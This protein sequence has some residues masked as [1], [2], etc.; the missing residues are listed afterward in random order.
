MDALYKD[1]H[2]IKKKLRELSRKVDDHLSD[3]SAH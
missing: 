2:V 3:E 1:C